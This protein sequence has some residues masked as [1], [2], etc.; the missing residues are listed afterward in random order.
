MNLLQILPVNDT[1]FEPSPYSALSAFA[2]NPI[3]LRI[4][5]LPELDD[6]AARAYGSD[7]KTGAG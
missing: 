3:Y 2:L 5:D 7:K 1:G 4:A 6:A